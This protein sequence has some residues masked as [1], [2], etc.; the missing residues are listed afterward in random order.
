M[1]HRKERPSGSSLHAHGSTGTAEGGSMSRLSLTRSPVSPLAAQG[2]PLPAQLT[3]SNAPVHIDVGGHMYTSSLAT[4]TKYPDSRISRLFNGTEPI[5]LD[6]LKQHYFIDRDGEIFRYVLSFLRTSKLLLPDDFKGD[7]ATPSAGAGWKSS[8]GLGTGAHQLLPGW[9]TS[10]CCT[11]RRATTSCS[12]WCA[13]WSAG[14]RNR[15]S[16]AAAGPATAWWCASRR[17]W[18][19]GSR[20][21]ARRLSSRRSSPRPGTSCATRS[22]PA[23]TRTPRTSSASRSTATA[24]STRC[25]SWRGCSRGVSAWLRPAGVAWTPP[26]SA[27]TCFAG[28]SGGRSPP[29]LLSK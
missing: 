11:R 18:V 25:R 21:A 28:R 22:T 9:R 26:S 16:G 27:N 10:A 23:G 15:S 2:I 7:E 24:G 4:L 8:G 5:V 13:S 3:K 17:T 1:P 6:S 19:S 29:P 20:S 12:P 14:S